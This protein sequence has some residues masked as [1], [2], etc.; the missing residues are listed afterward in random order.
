MVAFS[1]RGEDQFVTLNR[2]SQTSELANF[3]TGDIVVLYPNLNNGPGVLHQQIFKGSL[4]ELDQHKVVI[5][6]KSR[7]HN[8]QHF[9]SDTF[10]NIEHD[11]LDSSFT[12]MYRIS[13]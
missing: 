4:I 7:Q 12:N 6:L 9:D 3:R 10:W 1:N 11:M 8:T 2:T 5:R 13:L